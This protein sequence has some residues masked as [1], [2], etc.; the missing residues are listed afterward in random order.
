MTLGLTIADGLLQLLLKT[1]FL[2]KTGEE[3]VGHNYQSTNFICITFSHFR[4]HLDLPFIKK[5]KKSIQNVSF[6]NIAEI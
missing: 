2:I 3:D 6:Q 5:K 1:L 4:I